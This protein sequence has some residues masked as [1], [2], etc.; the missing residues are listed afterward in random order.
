MRRADLARGERGQILVIA[1]LMLVTLLGFAGLAIDV[2]WYHLNTMRIQRAADAAA[3]AGVVYLPG[4]PAGAMGMARAESAKNGYADGV[5]G[6]IVTAVQDAINDRL[7]VVTVRGTMQTFFARF[8]GMTTF[9]AERRARAE[10]I[11]PVPMGSPQAYFG[12]Y[13][14]CRN[15]DTPPCPNIPDA[16][17]VGTVPSQGFWAAVETR[18]AQRTSGDAYSTEFDAAQSGGIN[19]AFDPL[20]YSYIVEFPAGTINGKVWIYDPVFC[21]TGRKVS[22]GSNRLGV[23][24]AYIARPTSASERQI[25]TEFKLWDMKNTPYST[26]DDV[27]VASDLG[28]FTNSQ[29]V[30]RDPGSPYFGNGRFDL[31]NSYDGSAGTDCSAS[32]Y[33]NAWWPLAVGLT[34]GQYRLQAT[35]SSGTTSQ[36]AVNNFALQATADSGTGLRIYGQTR[37]AVF[38]SLP[39]TSSLFYLAQIDAVHAGKTLEIKLFDPGDFPN[40]VLRIRQPTSSAYV[41]A[42]F[43]WTA[44]GSSGGAPTSGT[45]VTSLTT[46]DSRTN[47]Y[48]NQWITLRVAL[49]TSYGVGGITPPGEPGPGWWKILYTTGTGGGQ[50]VTTWEVNIRGNPVHLIIP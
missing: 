20:G 43:S 31:G 32:P 44:T 24:D 5:S 21:A 22:G 17:G 4:D 8:F 40:T 33:H 14:L 19:A 6:A 38:L 49:P 15:S 34:Q 27:L 9:R 30:N 23:G 50:D 37:M 28:L 42:T 46:S 45:N 18:G 39:S 25:T 12:V 48:N 3:L 47:F 1:A 2:G 35:T 11:L 10:F 13:N 7:L 16:S 41:D 29:G 26:A 36:N